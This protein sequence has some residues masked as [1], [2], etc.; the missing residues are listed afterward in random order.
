MICQRGRLKLETE[1][2]DVEGASI[3]INWTELHFFCMAWFAFVSLGCLTC[4]HLISVTLPELISALTGHPP[5][6]LSIHLSVRVCDRPSAHP[7]NNPPNCPSV[8]FSFAHPQVVCQHP[9]VRQSGRP[10]SS[11]LDC[12]GTEPDALVHVSLL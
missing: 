8:C 7:S 4:F 2:G 10:R 6:H 1:L 5:I 9:S 3:G 12:W 11:S